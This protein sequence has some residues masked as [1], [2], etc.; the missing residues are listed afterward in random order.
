MN[1]EANITF[2]STISWGNSRDPYTWTGTNAN[3]CMFDRGF[4]GHE[5]LFSFGLINMNGRMYDP[6]MSSFLSVD[7]Y[8]QSPENSQ[9]FNRYSY[10]LNNPLK[11]TDPSG[12]RMIG[13]NTPKIYGWG[14]GCHVVCEP[15]DL[16]LRQLPEESIGIYFPENPEKSGG[17]TTGNPNGSEIIVI[18]GS[19]GIQTVY[20]PGMNYTG[21]DELTRN[22]VEKLNLVSSK[23]NTAK[24]MIDEL[25]A[26]GDLVYSIEHGDE[27]QYVPNGAIVGS[28][29]SSDLFYQSDGGTVYWNE[30]GTTTFEKS[31]EKSCAE[32]NIRPDMDLFHE[33]CHAWDD[34]SGFLAYRSM[35]Y[36]DLQINEWSAIRIEN[37]IR[38][39]LGI[40][41]KSHYGTNLAGDKPGIPLFSIGG[42]YKFNKY[43]KQGMYI[44]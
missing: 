26:S 2:V 41:L 16:G 25:V 29:N 38:T 8:V 28:A 31:A 18:V 20:S 1:G 27:S 44:H 15:R 30:A 40:P 34:Y 22:A 9:N 13:G 14:L 11:Y 36:R 23:S 21:T 7:N 10:C 4:T 17:G 35:K 24:M 12:W 6:V 37:M 3:R 39:E 43:E 33:L 19:D 32:S 42:V 5:H